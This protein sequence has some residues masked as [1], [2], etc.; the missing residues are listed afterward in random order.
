MLGEWPVYRYLSTEQQQPE[1]LCWDGEDK[2]I[3]D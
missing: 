2:G 3:H 1:R